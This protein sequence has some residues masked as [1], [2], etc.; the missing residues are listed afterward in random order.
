MPHKAVRAPTGS[1]IVHFEFFDWKVKAD[2]INL[3]LRKKQTVV[4]NQWPRSHLSSCL[5]CWRLKNRVDDNYQIGKTNGLMCLRYIPLFACILSTRFGGLQ[6]M[7]NVRCSRPLGCVAVLNNVN[8][9]RSNN[10]F[11][12]DGIKN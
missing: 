1:L 7:Q 9:F 10:D 5:C 12:G 3:C 4:I 2:Y 8:L 6:N 11:S